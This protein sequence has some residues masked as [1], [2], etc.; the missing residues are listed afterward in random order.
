M[1]NSTA[2]VLDREKDTRVRFTRNDRTVLACLE[3][4][5]SPMKAYDLLECLRQEGI[6]A[7]MTIYRALGRLVGHGRVRKIE[8]LNAYYAV[9]KG[10]EGGCGAFL[11]CQDCG[12]IGFRQLDTALVSDLVD[13]LQI[14]DAS[15]ELK[16]KCLAGDEELLSGKCSRHG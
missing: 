2:A 3:R 16:T 4:Q 8:S 14:V 13:D 11:I 9:P 10:E 5:N 12:A 7:P 15:I 6:N 1:L